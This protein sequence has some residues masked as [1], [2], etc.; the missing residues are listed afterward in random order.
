MA[1]AFLKNMIGQGGPKFVS[2]LLSLFAVLAI[3]ALSFSR[4]PYIEHQSLVVALYIG[5]VSVLGVLAYCLIRHRRFYIA[6]FAAIFSSVTY[7]WLV[8]LVF[9]AGNCMH[10]MQPLFAVILSLLT[11]CSLRYLLLELGSRELRTEFTADLSGMPRAN[12]QHEI[13]PAGIGGDNRVVTVIFTDIKGFTA[14]S[15]Q[16]P[17]KEVVA[18]LNE[19][20]GEMVQIIE[21]YDGYVDKFIGDGIMAY[22]GAPLAQKD[23]ADLA[24]A[25]LLAMQSAMQKLQAKWLAAGEEPF[26]IRAGV[27]SGE[28]V[29]G[30]I[31]LRG[32]KME[33]T[34]IGDTVN[35]AS[36]LETSAKYYGVDTLVGEDTYLRTRE[37]YNYRELDRVRMVGKQLPV[38]VYELIGPV[39]AQPRRW[40]KMFAEA[41]A[42]YRA[43]DWIAAEQAFMEITR[44][45]PQDQPSAMYLERCQY[46]IKHP[47]ASDWDGVF[48]RSVK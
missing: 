32:K 16:R 4:S 23:H 37:V 18:R 10:M 8:L 24:I 44:E 3:T 36:R 42:V 40:Q 27:Q 6:L 38:T 46:F 41:L 7:A 22:W 12:L 13:A 30:N 5:F 11:G 35:Q 21:E 19:Y 33:Y 48:V 45:F 43:H 34:V 47:A 20:L 9:G 15:E 39:T 25:C 29:A 28:V 1:V 14:F 31:G 2:L 17:P 26:T